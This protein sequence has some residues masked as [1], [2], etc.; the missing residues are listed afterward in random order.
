MR[1]LP[2]VDQENRRAIRDERAKDPLV[3]ITPIQERLKERF[4]RELTLIEFDRT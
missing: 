4:E 2:A 3:P 1:I